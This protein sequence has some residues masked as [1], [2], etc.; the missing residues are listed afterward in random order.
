MIT[1]NLKPG[2]TLKLGDL[3]IVNIKEIN[4]SMVRFGI[5][6]PRSVAVHRLEI[7]HKIK[8]EGAK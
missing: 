1:F 8:D 4:K 7:Y 5:E 6:A 3:V 2:D